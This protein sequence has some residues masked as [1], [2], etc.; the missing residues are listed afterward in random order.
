MLIPEHGVETCYLVSPAKHKLYLDLG[1]E[2]LS[3]TIQWHHTQIA[4]DKAVRA[5]TA[6]NISTKEWFFCDMK[7]PKNIQNEKW[8]KLFLILLNKTLALKKC[9]QLLNF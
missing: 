6:K 4:E 5:E 2:W 8:I 1:Y 7:F 3:I 9:G